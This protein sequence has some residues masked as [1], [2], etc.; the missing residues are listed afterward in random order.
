MLDRGVVEIDGPGKI[1]MSSPPSDKII[2]GEF[3]YLGGVDVPCHQVPVANRL[4][5]KSLAFGINANV[6]GLLNPV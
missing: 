3:P 5:L 6:A 2:G 4:T 1:G